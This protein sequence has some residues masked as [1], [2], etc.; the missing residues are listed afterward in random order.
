VDRFLAT[1]WQTAARAELLSEGLR[2]SP[3][4]AVARRLQE[5]Q[6]AGDPTKAELVD[7][8]SQQLAVQQKMER[9]LLDFYDRMEQV[10]VELDTVRGHLIT[11]SASTEADN[12]ERLADDVRD[13]RE[14]MG[15][16]AEGMAA[17]YS[18]QPDRR[19][20][21]EREAG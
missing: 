10:L 3:P 6:A 19:G 2:D 7:A 20:V 14:E 12:Q 13:L 17:A 4:E 1:M 15:A 16:V 18:R 21:L 8:L 5:V 9:Q 11:V